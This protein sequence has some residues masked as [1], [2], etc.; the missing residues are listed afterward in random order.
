MRVIF[1]LP[2]FVEKERIESDFN[3]RVSKWPYSNYSSAYSSK[4]RVIYL[5]HITTRNKDILTILKLAFDSIEIL[6]IEK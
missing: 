4:E 5:Y 6:N 2:T 3:V 1:G